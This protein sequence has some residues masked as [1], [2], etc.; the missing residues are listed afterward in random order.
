MMSRLVQG[1]LEHSFLFGTNTVNV[2]NIFDKSYRP[3]HLQVVQFVIFYVVKLE[4][5]TSF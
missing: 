5:L 1:Y 2:V 4:N 3:T